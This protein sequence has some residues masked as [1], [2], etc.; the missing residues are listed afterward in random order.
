MPALTINFIIVKSFMPALRSL[1]PILHCLAKK[2]LID[3]DQRSLNRFVKSNHRKTTVG[4]ANPKKGFSL[5]GSIK[6]GLWC[7][8][9]R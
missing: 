7:N 1:P 4:E 6:I 5:L 9:R 3:R 2:I 8:G